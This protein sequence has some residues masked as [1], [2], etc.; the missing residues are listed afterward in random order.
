MFLPT[1][2]PR[3]VVAYF[4]GG[5]EPTN[6]GFAYY[7]WVLFENGT[8]IT[9]GSGTIGWDRTNNE[10][11]YTAAIEAVHAA[12]GLR[13]GIPKLLRGDSQ[14]VIRQLEERYAVRAERIIPLFR[15]LKDLVNQ[16]AWAFEW[17]PR[18]QNE[19]ADLEGRKAAF[20]AIGKWP[21]RGRMADSLPEGIRLDGS[22]V[23]PKPKRQG[24]LDGFRKED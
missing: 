21:L 16:D 12:N 3:S 17:V 7:G 4:D 13:S 19:D 20:R 1:R 14:L 18:E 11:E 23:P 5:A 8:R 10:A 22:P 6:P 15:R 9:S 24:T 2:G